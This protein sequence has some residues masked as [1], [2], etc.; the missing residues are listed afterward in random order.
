MSHDVLER[1]LRYEWPG[2]VRELRNVIEGAFLKARDGCISLSQL[3]GQFLRQLDGARLLPNE[4]EHL[5]ETLCSTNWNKSRAAEQL[6]WSRM[7]LYRRMAKYKIAQRLAG[8]LH[9]QAQ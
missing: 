5:L 9:R 6:R 7:T 2:N 3:P 4:R 8:T 1:L